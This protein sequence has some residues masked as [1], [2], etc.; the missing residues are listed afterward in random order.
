[1]VS[2]LPAALLGDR[3]ADAVPLKG[4]RVALAIL[5]LAIGVFVGVSALRLV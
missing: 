2:S 3:L 4:I 1:M 5:F